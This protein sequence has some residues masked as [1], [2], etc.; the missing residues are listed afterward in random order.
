MFEQGL[1]PAKVVSKQLCVTEGT[2]AKWRLYGTGPDFIRVGRRIAYDPADV[3]A[4]LNARRV[5]STSE[6]I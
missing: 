6:A 5:N 1:I 3:A 4:W 2:L